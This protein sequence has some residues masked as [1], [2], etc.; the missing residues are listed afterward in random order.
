M[1][2][3]IQTSSSAAGGRFL[4]GLLIIVGVIGSALIGIALWETTSPGA[5]IGASVGIF[6]NTLIVAYVLLMLADATD[7]VVYL[8]RDRDE[9]WNEQDEAAAPMPLPQP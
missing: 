4:G 9:Q 7:A 2:H 8:A 5:A 3:W 1:N 6:A